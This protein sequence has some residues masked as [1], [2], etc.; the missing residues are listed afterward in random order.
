MAASGRPALYTRG[1][2]VVRRLGVSSPKTFLISKPLS[3]SFRH[4]P[5]PLDVWYSKRSLKRLV[6][7]WS[8]RRRY[9]SKS[10]RRGHNS[11]RI[12]RWV[13][14]FCQEIFREK[15]GTTIL[16]CQCMYDFFL[17]TMHICT[18]MI[19]GYLGQHACSNC[20]TKIQSTHWRI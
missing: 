17:F 16:F 10:L 15:S 9:Q 6:F 3:F 19:A 4:L 8:T 13:Q 5:T 11:S 14:I 7:R 1:S 12:Q 18:F 20:V 2:T